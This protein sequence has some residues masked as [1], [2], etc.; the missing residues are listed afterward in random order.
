MQEL[1]QE[2]DNNIV[3]SLNYNT[4]TYGPIN[5]LHWSADL[6]LKSRP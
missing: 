3:A 2:Q 6:A 5:I 1:N 4:C